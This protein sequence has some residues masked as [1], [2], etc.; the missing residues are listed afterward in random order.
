MAGYGSLKKMGFLPC[1]RRFVSGP[2]GSAFVCAGV[3]FLASAWLPAAAQDPELDQDPELELK[4][5]KTE[6]K[7]PD[8]ENGLTL[9]RKL[10]TTCHLIGEP[11]D[12]P[13]PADVPSFPSIANRP[14]QS[15]EALTN[16]LM[17]PHAP[18]PDPHLT[19]IE[20]RDLTGYILSLRTAE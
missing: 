16:W 1:A 2:V 17:A 3:V 5:N 18:M 12:A 6:S 8:L 9:A 4:Q 19:R 11:V 20:I 15:A 7:V 13:A 10:C 14:N